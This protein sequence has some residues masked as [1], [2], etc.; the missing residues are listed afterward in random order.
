MDETIFSSYY[1]YSEQNKIKTL[2]VW[3]R[4]S[5]NYYDK[6]YSFINNVV[7]NNYIIDLIHPTKK[8]LLLG[9]RDSQVYIHAVN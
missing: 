5:D 6:G 1:I 8:S 3:I 2:L 4:W 7:Y 9:T